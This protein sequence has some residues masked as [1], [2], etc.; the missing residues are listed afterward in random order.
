MSAT[1]EKVY[2]RMTI[3]NPK[4]NGTG[5]RAGRHTLDHDQDRQI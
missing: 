4:R 1:T 2:A 5:K 3:C